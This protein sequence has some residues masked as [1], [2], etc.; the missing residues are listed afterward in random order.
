MTSKSEKG[1]D[2]RAQIVAAARIEFAKDGYAGAALSDIVASAKVTTG[3]VYYHF[4]GKKGLFL[5][6][7]ESIEQAILDE[8]VQLAPP[9][10]TDWE[11]LEKGVEAALEIC[12]RPDIQRIVFIDAPT[13]I[14]LRQWR[15]VEMKYAYGVFRQ[16]L[17]NL[18]NCEDVTI[19]NPDLSAQIL[20]GTIIEAAH[21]V[22]DAPKKKDALNEAKMMVLT[23]LRA[24]KRQN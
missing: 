11:M 18:V 12:A 7:A 2:T 24:I 13:V 21:A 19:S 15:E 5:A 6:V 1:T 23:M 20:L 17:T 14:G 4:G 8:V 9:T 16:S 3:A 22:A 10:G